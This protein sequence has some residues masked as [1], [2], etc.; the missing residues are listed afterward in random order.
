VASLVAALR[1]RRARNADLA[2]VA[3]AGAF[4][5]TVFVATL[6]M[7]RDL[8]LS[9]GQ[10]GLGFVPLAVSAG[11]GGPLAARLVARFGV[12]DTVSCSLVITAACLGWLA[13]AA[14]GDA[15]AVAIPPVFAVAGASFA[16]AAV[17]LTAEAMAGAADKGAAAGL[18]QTFTHAGGALV[19]TA[20]AGAAAAFG[21]RAAFGLIAALLLAG[22]LHC[23]FTLHGRF[24]RAGC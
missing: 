5:A 2:I 11:L 19:L 17:P 21:H 23:A 4:G 22:A 10:A 8:G 15:Y 12:R 7:Q 13:R 14:P 1:D 16:V 24:A 18:F 6:V 3:N 20:A 9:A